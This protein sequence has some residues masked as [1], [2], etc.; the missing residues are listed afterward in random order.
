MDLEAGDV[1]AGVDAIF[2]GVPVRVPGVRS[3][4]DPRVFLDCLSYSS[5]VDAVTPH[6]LDA[7]EEFL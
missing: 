7:L 2:C 6:F 4:R 1:E 3:G 5:E